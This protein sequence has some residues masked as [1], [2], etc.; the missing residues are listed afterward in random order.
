MTTHINLV[1]P[2]Y[3][4]CRRIKRRREGVYFI[5]KMTD[6]KITTEALASLT[7]GELKLLFR[8]NQSLERAGFSSNQEESG[9]ASSLSK[10]SLIKPFGKIGDRIR[11]QVTPMDV[12]CRNFL[13]ELAN[14]SLDELAVLAMGGSK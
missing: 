9:Y 2:C 1:P 12:D 4:Y 3:N 11:W 5:G 10:K 7:I 14:P 13:R 6:G 8:L